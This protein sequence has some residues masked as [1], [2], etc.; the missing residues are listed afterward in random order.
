MEEIGRSKPT[1]IKIGAFTFEAVQFALKP[2]AERLSMKQR[3]GKLIH[4]CDLC[5]SREEHWTESVSIS[6]R[7]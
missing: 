7:R 1:Y 3:K 5:V 6:Q 2:D 4:G